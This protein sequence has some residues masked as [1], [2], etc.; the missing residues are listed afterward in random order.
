[1]KL[2]EG[3][4]EWLIYGTNLS[5]GETVTV[6]VLKAEE[7]SVMISDGQHC[8]DCFLSLT[9]VP[10]VTS[11]CIGRGTIIEISRL[12]LTNTDNGVICIIAQATIVAKMND[13]IGKPSYCKYNKKKRVMEQC[14]GEVRKARANEIRQNFLQKHESEKDRHEESNGKKDFNDVGVSCETCMCNPC[15]WTYYGNDI[16]DELRLHHL[17]K[18]ESEV[19]N[20]ELRFLAYTA[21]TNIKHGFLG[22]SVRRK[23]PSCVECGI[24][25]N[26]PDDENNYVGFKEVEKL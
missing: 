18:D 10:L 8:L 7:R 4:I 3:C 6:Q 2:S 11:G 15:D 24:R 19:T 20:K 22:K 14:D 5:P 1:M 21:Y 26:F 17:H 16:I 23:V 13:I 9:L 12:A 25:M